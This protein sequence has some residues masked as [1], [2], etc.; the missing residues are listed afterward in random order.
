[1]KIFSLV[2]RISEKAYAQASAERSYVFVVPTNV[3]KIDVIRAVKEQFDVDAVAV[4]TT[5]LKGKQKRTY[6]RGRVERGT[7]SDLKKAYV[8]LKPRQSIPLFAS[9]EPAAEQPKEKK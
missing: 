9:E 4:N 1:M 3:T 8:T 7:R 6:R 2:P 5:T